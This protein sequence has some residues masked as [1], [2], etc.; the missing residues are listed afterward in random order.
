MQS[1]MFT[2]WDD[3]PWKSSRTRTETGTFSSPSLSPSHISNNK[4]SNNTQTPHRIHYRCWRTLHCVCHVV[5]WGETG[6]QDKCDERIQIRQSFEI[7]AFREGY[8]SK[9]SYESISWICERKKRI[10]CTER[11]ESQDTSMFSCDRFDISFWWERER[12]RYERV[13]SL[14]TE[15]SNYLRRNRKNQ[16][17]WMSCS[18]HAT[19]NAFK[20]NVLRSLWNIRN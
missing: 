3:P 14:E 11:N 9:S 12:G 5:M 16:G 1:R 7:H 17:W 6:S 19:E 20:W 10:L 2:I 8:R 13:C 4:T 18:H 15:M